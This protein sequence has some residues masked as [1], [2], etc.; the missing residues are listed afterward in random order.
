MCVKSGYMPVIV[1]IEEGESTESQTAREWMENSRFHT[2]EAQDIFEALEEMG[3]FT[4]DSR[5]EVILLDVENCKADLPLV[6]GTFESV[7]QNDVSI[8]AIS[9]TSEPSFDRGAFEGNLEA[10]VAHLDE[11]LPETAV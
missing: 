5:P 2:T 11:I 10:V 8:M 1:M 9:A 4:T 6:R 7:N 3:D